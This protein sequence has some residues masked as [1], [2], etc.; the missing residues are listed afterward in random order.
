ML[1]DSA[2]QVLWSD[3][4]SLPHEAIEQFH[5]TCGEFIAE[6]IFDWSCSTLLLYPLA[7]YVLGLPS[8]GERPWPPDFPVRRLV[9]LSRYIRQGPGTA[10]P[11]NCVLTHTANLPI[12]KIECRSISKGEGLA[13]FAALMGWDLSS[14]VSVGDDEADISMFQQTQSSITFISA[15]ATVRE[16]A[17]LHI[18]AIDD[19]LHLF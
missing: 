3:S 12:T 18:G 2:R 15:P 11:D 10:I 4:A 8:L 1:V 6:G 14:A 17:R 13:R 19:I 9:T 16:A 5:T 7:K